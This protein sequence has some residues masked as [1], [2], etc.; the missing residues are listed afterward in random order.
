MDSIFVLWL[1]AGVALLVPTVAYGTKRLKPKR[2]YF[3]LILFAQSIVYLHIF[4][5]IFA[6]SPCLISSVYPL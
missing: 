1:L 5:S 3:F 4:P 2:D 6:A